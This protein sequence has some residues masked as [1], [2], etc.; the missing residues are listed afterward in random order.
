MPKKFS[1][2]LIT[3]QIFY[4]LYFIFYIFAVPFPARADDS[5]PDFDMPE[6][7]IDISG[8]DFY[9]ECEKNDDRW[10]CSIPWIAQYI[11]AIYKYAIGIVGILATVVM[12]VGGIIWLTAG[13]NATRVGEAKSWISASL[14]GLVIALSSY[15][16]LY[17]INPELVNLKPIKVTV[18]KKIKTTMGETCRWTLLTSSDTGKETCEDLKIT[19]AED[20]SK[21]GDKGEKTTAYGCCCSTGSCQPATTGSCTETNLSKTCFKD[22]T[23]EASSIC[24]AESSGS[25]TNKN[26]KATCNY[27]GKQYYVVLGLFQINI[28]AND[29]V[30]SDGN[31]T[32][33]SSAFDKAYSNTSTNCNIE[34]FSLYTECYNKMMTGDNNIATACNLFSI[35]NTWEPWEANSDTCHFKS[36]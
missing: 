7:Q 29:I 32:N 16:I 14:T 17:Q 9:Y 15:L 35:G 3:F 2:I 34:D 13:G 23:Y 28:S 5:L 21:C 22:N 12:M 25:E 30:D 8:D 11:V 26:T 18:V 6:L 27:N 36:K 10:T 24:M 33:C 20:E 1:K 19:T 31:K 4:I